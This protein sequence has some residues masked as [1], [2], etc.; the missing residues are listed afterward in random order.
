METSG[1]IK[2]ADISEPQIE[3]LTDKAENILVIS[4]NGVGMSAEELDDALGTIAKSGT[5][6]F[7]KA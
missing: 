4:D 1:T 6:E 7:Y 5:A 3:I 2:E